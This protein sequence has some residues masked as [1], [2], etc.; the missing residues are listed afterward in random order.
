[1]ILRKMLQH[2]TNTHFIHESYPSYPRAR[3]L[4]SD[5]NYD[6]SFELEYRGPVAM[7]GKP[8]PMQCWFLTRGQG[9]ALVPTTPTVEDVPN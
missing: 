7:K 1:M 9:G 2:Y 3:L 4:A 8:E 6:Q 5:M